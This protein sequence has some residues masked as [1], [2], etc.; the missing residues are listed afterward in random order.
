MHS[1]NDTT[2]PGVRCRRLAWQDPFWPPVDLDGLR[3][4]LQL[5]TQISEARLEV[6]ARFAAHKAAD[7]FAIWRRVLRARG[8]QQLGELPSHERLGHRYLRAVQV[9][10][11]WALARD[12]TVVD[13]QPDAG[14]GQGHE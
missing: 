14:G 2:G 6:A 10:T 3:A 13:R 1:E 8:Y 7:E 5:S 11:Q 12:L 4:Q 9:H